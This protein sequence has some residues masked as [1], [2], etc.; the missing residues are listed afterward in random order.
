VLTIAATIPIDST[1]RAIHDLINCL[2]SIFPPS[3]S[4][5]PKDV[6]MQTRLKPI[7]V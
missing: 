7:Q 2:M 3:L 4:G 1:A 5:F 6:S